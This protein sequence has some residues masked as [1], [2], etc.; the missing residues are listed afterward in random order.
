MTKRAVRSVGTK[1]KI[2]QNFIGDLSSIGSPSI[3]QEELDV[4]TLDS[5]GGYRE[6]IAGFKDPGEVPISGF[7]VPSDLGQADVYA[8]LESGDIQ[9]F[10]IIYPAKLGT[11]WSFKGIITAFN[12]T[13]ETEDA[14]G[15]EATIRVS[16]KPSLDTGV[17]TGLTALTLTGADGVLSPGF[18]PAVQ[19]Y[20]FD[21]VTDPSFTVTATAA[22]HRLALY[23]DGVYKEDLVSGQPSS[24]V[25]FG[26]V[27]SRKVTIVAKESGKA[28]VAYEIVVVSAD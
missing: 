1:I 19:Y 10:E 20:T 3:T 14:I 15:F 12:V 7:F 8:A 27:K 11:S 18:E 23:V 24:P 26:A 28:S 5:E 21:G 2:G 6:V 9:D 22:N 13:A 25:E 16:G 17:S 4:T